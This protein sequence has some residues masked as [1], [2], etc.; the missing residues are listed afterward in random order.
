MKLK[1]GD[2][3]I[4]TAGKDKGRKGKIEKV[5]P[6]KNK[7]LVS[8][9]N[10]YKKN[11]KAKSEKETGGIVE[12]PRPLPASNVV[13]ICPKCKKPTRVGHAF[14]QKGKKQRICKKCK[15]TIN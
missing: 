3:V 11:V 10:L 6:K 9:L 13:L 2:T 1:K 15:K 7:V 4:V 14:S 8:G 12:I 5:H